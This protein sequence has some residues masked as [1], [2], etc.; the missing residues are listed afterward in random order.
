M[1]H[2][3]IEL[4]MFFLFYFHQMALVWLQKFDFK[5]IGSILQW[6]TAIAFFYFIFFMGKFDYNHWININ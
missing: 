1:N 3:T 6:N 2:Q 5:G 4:Q